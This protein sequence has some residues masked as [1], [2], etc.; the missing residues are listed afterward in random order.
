[1]NEDKPDSAATLC[2]SCEIEMEYAEG[3]PRAIC[4]ECGSQ[5]LMKM[6]NPKS[7]YPTKD[8][9]LQE[10]VIYYDG[11]QTLWRGRDR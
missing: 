5:Y 7:N 4:H 8:N 6:L 2:P 9:P 11:E 1:M 10:M 3:V